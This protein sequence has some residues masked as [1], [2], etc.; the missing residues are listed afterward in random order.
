MQRVLGRLDFVGSTFSP[1]VALSPN[2][3]NCQSVNGQCTSVSVAD[4]GTGGRGDDLPLP[5]LCP[6]PCPS[7][8]R[9]VPLNPTE[10]AGGAL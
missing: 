10:G 8:P 5:V 4:T 3:S 9:S 1:L 7:L 2:G 6:I